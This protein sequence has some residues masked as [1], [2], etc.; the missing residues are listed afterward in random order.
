MKLHIFHTATLL[1]TVLCL[2]Q[3]GWA[4]NLKEYV[5]QDPVLVEK[6]NYSSQDSA[7][8][9]S[10]GLMVTGEATCTGHI[11]C[12]Y[13][14][15]IGGLNIGGGGTLS[16]SKVCKPISDDSCSAFCEPIKISNG[17]IYSLSNQ[18]GECTW[19]E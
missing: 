16:Y 9:S 8:D 14:I 4:I 1:F 5:P 2:Y 7:A 17:V 6:V 10:Q 11:Q 3:D 12:D 15:G 13:S 18:L 19:E